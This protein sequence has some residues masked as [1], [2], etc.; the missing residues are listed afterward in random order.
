M[1][2]LYDGPIFIFHRHGILQV[3]HVS[4]LRIL[5]DHSGLAMAGMTLKAA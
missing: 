1:M 3:S 2:G 5:L 4:T